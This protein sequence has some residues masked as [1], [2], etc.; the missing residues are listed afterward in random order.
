MPRSKAERNFHGFADPAFHQDFQQDLET[1]GLKMKVLNT[2][3]SYH[4][5]PRKRVFNSQVFSLQWCRCQSAKPRDQQPKLVPIR[6][7]LSRGITACDGDIVS[8]HHRTN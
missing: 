8:I 3:S 4:K 2:L 5:K 7:A 1:L 6:H